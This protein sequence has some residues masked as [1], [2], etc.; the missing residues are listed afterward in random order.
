MYELIVGKDKKMNLKE[1]YEETGGSLEEVLK[2]L[3]GEAMIKKY[4]LK[5]GDDPSYE[6]LKNAE[7]AADIKGA[8]LA[9]HTI[10]GLCANL[11]IARL[12]KAASELTEKLRSAE[13]MPPRES[14][15]D[16]DREYRHTA[17]CISKLL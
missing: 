5:F 4:V 1:F 16:V 8:F 7:S 17:E 9:A 2:R 10:K 3:P 14:F 13:K 15:E 6:A 11:G 12:E